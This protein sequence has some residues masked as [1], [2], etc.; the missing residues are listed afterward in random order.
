M[1]AKGVNA[2]MAVI[3][4]GATGGMI[5]SGLVGLFVGAVVMLPGYTLLAA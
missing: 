3:F 2:P 1:L 4:L 5:F